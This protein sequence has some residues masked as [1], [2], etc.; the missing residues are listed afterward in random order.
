MLIATFSLPHEA[1]A[2]EQ[3][4]EELPELQVEAE[5]IAA[6]SRA[7][8]MPCLWAANAEFD[9]FDDVLEADSTVEEIVDGFEFSDEKYYQLLQVGRF[10]GRS[11]LTQ[12]D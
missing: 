11:G 12:P 4:F 6:H 8:V 7:W 3:A 2:L 5:R 10:G 1:V 9:A